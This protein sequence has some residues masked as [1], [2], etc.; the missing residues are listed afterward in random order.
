MKKKVLIVLVLLIFFDVPLLFSEP[1]EISSIFT[2]VFFRRE[3]DLEKFSKKIKYVRPIKSMGFILNYKYPYKYKELCVKLDSL[4]LR[5][6]EILDMHPVGFKVD[7]EI[8]NSKKDMEKYFVEEFGYRKK[9]LIAYYVPSKNKIYVRVDKINEHILAHEIGHA[10]IN[11]NFLIKPSEKIQEL[12][13]HFVD[14]NLRKKHLEDI[15][16]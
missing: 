12:L 7:I 16:Y 5:V 8:F 10:I 2:R 13:C 6:E 1:K 15:P 11:K 9:N 14:V 3:G 4:I